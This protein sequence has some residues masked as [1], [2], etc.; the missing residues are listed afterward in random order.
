MDPPRRFVLQLTDPMLAGTATTVKTGDLS[1][2]GRVS[3]VLQSAARHGSTSSTLEE[4]ARGLS[5]ERSQEAVEL[6]GLKPKT[7]S[8]RSDDPPHYR[9][10]VSARTRR[11]GQPLSM[12]H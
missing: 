5:E 1:F 10:V 7:D 6:R 2:V 8:S 9:D 11:T 12:S 3:S 4:H